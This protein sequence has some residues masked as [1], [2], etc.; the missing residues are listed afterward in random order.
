M[1]PL[2]SKDIPTTQQAAV[3]QDSNGDTKIVLTNIPV[4]TLKPGQI[5]VQ[6][7]WSGLCHSDIAVM[8]NYLLETPFKQMLLTTGNGIAGHEGVGRV[9]AMAED[10]ASENLWA[11]G[12]RVGIKWVSSTCGK[13]E[14]CM[15]GRDEVHC[16]EQQ[17]PGV[18]EPGTFQQYVATDARFA[19]RLPDGVADE[20]AAPLLCAGLTAYG[21]TKRSQVADGEWVVILGAGGGVGHLSL[22]YAK[23]AGMRTIAVDIGPE[24]EEMCRSLGADHFIDAASGQDIAQLVRDIVQ[25]GV[26]GVIVATLAEEAYEL[27]PSL[28]RPRGTMVTVAFPKSVT[29]KAGAS[30]LLIAGRMINIVGSTTGTRKEMEEVLNLTDRGVV[31]P[32]INKRPLGD[33][34]KVMDTIMQGKLLGK[35]VLRI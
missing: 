11:M 25:H 10:I 17:N 35:A 26:H 13:C 5:L 21:A 23:V 31:R 4:P 29:F 6:I 28:L 15:N 24:K 30:P 9:V 20:E 8:K 32:K 2:Y 33:L 22:Q 18:T 14:F 12:D 34:E 7:T 27:A 19:T 3:L 16:P 1:T